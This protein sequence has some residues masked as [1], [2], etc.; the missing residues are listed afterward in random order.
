[1]L[2][3]E[4]SKTMTD[5]KLTSLQSKLELLQT[6]KTQ[7]G[8]SEVGGGVAPEAA[9]EAIEGLLAKI[10]DSDLASLQ[11]ASKTISNTE[12]TSLQLKIW[13]L[14]QQPS[15]LSWLGWENAVVGGA[16]PEAVSDVHEDML[17]KGDVTSKDRDDSE[18]LSAAEAASVQSKLTLLQSKLQSELLQSKQQMA[19]LQTNKTQEGGSEVVGG[20]AAGAAPEVVPEASS[21]EA[22]EI[23]PA[24]GDV[25][26]EPLDLAHL[27][28]PDESEEA[29]DPSWKY[30]RPRRSAPVYTARCANRK[31][32][33]TVLEP[34]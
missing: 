17:I 30:P 16:A 27:N 8:G 12:L 23:A 24:S 13:S 7:E 20:V 15:V 14:G 29:E 1:M 6:N 11:E 2:L 26:T 25:P 34:E 31:Y 32:Q 18:P 10:S 5:A 21:A 19:L 3:Q 4:A 9:P 28:E 22:P 33:S